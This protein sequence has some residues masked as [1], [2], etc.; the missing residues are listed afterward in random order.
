MNEIAKKQ[1]CISMHSGQEVWIDS[2]KQGAVESQ[3]ADPSIRFIKVEG[4][5]LN[6]NSIAGIFL[7]DDMTDLIHRKNGEWQCLHGAWHTKNEKCDCGGL[8]KYPLIN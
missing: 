8:D 3:M 1:V 5:S 7:P 2:E 6:S 4:R